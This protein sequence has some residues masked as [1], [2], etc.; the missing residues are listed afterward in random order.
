M[1]LRKAS[2]TK[3]LD[4]KLQV[5]LE[6]RNILK[7]KNPLQNLTNINKVIMIHLILPLLKTTTRAVL[8]STSF[9]ALF[10]I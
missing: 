8:N 5:S 6:T 7:E 9:N 2:V 1:E 3:W 4:L 10:K